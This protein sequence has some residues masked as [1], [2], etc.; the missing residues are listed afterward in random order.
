MI[1][2]VHIPAP[3]LSQF[4]ASL[5]Y[6]CD[7]TPLTA[8]EKMLPT[9]GTGMVINLAEDRFTVEDESYRGA[10]W[11]G[12]FTKPFLLA[13]PQQSHTLGVSLQP[14]G[15]FPL[16]GLPASEISNQHLALE[17]LWGQKARCLRERLL[18]AGS[19]E[20]MFDIV[21]KFLLDLL[22][23]SAG[24]HPAVTYALAELSHTV[25]QRTVADIGASTGFSNSRFTSL[26][27]EQV[28]VTPKIYSRLCRFRKALD[29]IAATSQPDWAQLALDCGYYDQPH[30][31]HEFRDFAGLTPSVYAKLRGPHMNHVPLR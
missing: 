26:F 11:A 4:V 27:R 28:G 13:T 24:R 7:Y 20:S 21:E 29:L 8:V 22:Y 3:P 15:A 2:K 23:R 30:F 25:P 1:S 14:G 10:I 17:D 31:V 6:Y 19:P 16:L 18:T 12:L 9:A 5:W